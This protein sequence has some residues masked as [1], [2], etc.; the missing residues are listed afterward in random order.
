MLFVWIQS[1]LVLLLCCIPPLFSLLLLFL[2]HI[3]LNMCT[4]PIFLKEIKEVRCLL[5][6]DLD[7]AL[8]DCSDSPGKALSAHSDSSPAPFLSQLIVVVDFLCFHDNVLHS[9]L[10]VSSL[11]SPPSLSDSLAPPV[12]AGGRW[13]GLWR[14]A[15]GG[16]G[17]PDQRATAGDVHHLW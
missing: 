1:E 15:G 7:C 14:G 17:E 10:S 2:T 13:A 6:L 5:Q 9:H 8:S 16:G 12:K 4:N 11:I 3:I